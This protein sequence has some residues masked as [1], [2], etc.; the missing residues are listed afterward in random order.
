MCGD[1]NNAFVELSA[2]R[3]RLLLTDTILIGGQKR[4]V[5]K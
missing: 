1:S 5:K 2:V 4:S 3:Y